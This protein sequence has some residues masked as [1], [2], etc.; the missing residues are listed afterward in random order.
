MYGLHMYVSMESLLVFVVFSIS[1]GFP[2]R[3][4][5]KMLF[6]VL[7]IRHC[8]FHWL[9]KLFP[10]SVVYVV[11]R[12][13]HSIQPKLC[14]PSSTRILNRKYALPMGNKFWAEKWKQAVFCVCI[15][16][17]PEAGIMYLYDV[18]RKC[19]DGVCRCSNKPAPMNSNRQFHFQFY[20][21]ASRNGFHSLTLQLH[22]FFL[23][24]S[25]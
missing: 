15:H 3:K 22:P 7:N 19:V 9:D 20:F 13:T 24:H 21:V 6:H 11:L 14:I 16:V 4:S 18:N 17:L 23:C 1:N 8:E 12:T 2:P 10:Y 5:H 25:R